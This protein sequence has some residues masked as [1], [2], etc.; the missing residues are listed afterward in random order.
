MAGPAATDSTVE[1]SLMSIVNNLIKRQYLIIGFVIGCTLL[2]GIYNYK[3]SPTT[4][5]TKAVYKLPQSIP[6]NSFQMSP[7][8]YIITAKSDRVL[9]NIVK[10]I[11]NRV[12]PLPT[13]EGLKKSLVFELDTTNNTITAQA[14]ADTPKEPYALLTAWT[15][16][17]NST[18]LQRTTDAL[19]RDLKVSNRR[20]SVISAALAKVSADLA[21]STKK[22]TG[23]DDNV[24]IQVAI[25]SGY[26]QQYIQ[27]VLDKESLLDR[28]NNLKEISELEP[29][30]MPSVR[31]TLV[32]PRRVLNVVVSFVMSLCIIVLGIVLTSLPAQIKA[33]EQIVNR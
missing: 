23:S 31:G 15:K 7:T 12:T 19:E 29:I 22:A 4:Y 30:N 33:A 8:D 21:D 3:F 20:I 6:N 14:Y 25:Q 5:V 24:P 16:S 27:T 17:F 2:S 18:V 26:G 10:N 9:E 13:M 28:K 32:S 11:G 1:I